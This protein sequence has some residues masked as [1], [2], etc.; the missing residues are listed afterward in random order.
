[1][2]KCHEIGQFPGCHLLIE[3]GRHD[4]YVARLDVFDILPSDADLL[5]GSSGEHYLLRRVFAHQAVMELAVLGSHEDRLVTAHQTGA[6]ENNGF[7]EVPFRAN[8]ANPCQI[9]TNITP[10]IANGMTGGTRGLGTAKD[11]LTTPDVAVVQW[12]YNKIVFLINK[13]DGT[14]TFSRSTYEF[15]IES[16]YSTIVAADIDL[17]GAAKLQ[18]S[19][20]A[21]NLFDEQHTFF[22]SGSAAS[23]QLGI[24]NEPRTWGVDAT[25]R[26]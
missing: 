13:N 1:M 24:F 10:Q 15:P 6:R 18:L 22:K 16:G 25:I 3:P 26:F 9:G 2:E 4:G 23:L 14:G 12:A 19:L 5:M 17:D 8:A 7:Q 21:R 11:C 20:W